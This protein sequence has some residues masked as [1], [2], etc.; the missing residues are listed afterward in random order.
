MNID[1]P[2]ELGALVRN[3][4]KQLKVNQT[5]LAMTCGTG[6]RFIV[7]IEKGKPTCQIGKV[8]AVLKAL[9]LAIEVNTPRGYESRDSGT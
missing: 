2:V 6:L 3:R 5:E 4:R 8:L 9:G 1:N 7:D